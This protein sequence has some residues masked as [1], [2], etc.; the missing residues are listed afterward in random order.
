M[1]FVGID[2]E[3]ALISDERPFPALTCLTWYGPK[4]GEGL[5]LHADAPARALDIFQRAANGEFVVIAHN[6]AFDLAVLL[7]E[8]PQL[9]D[10][11]WRMLD[12]SAAQCTQLRESLS[13]LARGT[14]A[15]KMEGDAR[16]RWRT[17]PAT[18]QR[19]FFKLDL[20]SSL[21]LR[22]SIRIDK[23]KDTWRLRY[24]ALRDVPLD[25]WPPD[26]LTYAREDAQAH[27]LLARLQ[28][29]EATARPAL[30]GYNELADAPAQTRAAWALAL[31]RLAGIQTDPATT[32]AL[33]AS[34]AARAVAV[35]DDLIAVGL[36]R[37]AGFLVGKDGSLRP[38][39]S[40]TNAKDGRRTKEIQARVVAALGDATP[41][42]DKGSVSASEET[43]TLTGDPDLVK[44]ADFAHVQKL[45]SFAEGLDKGFAPRAIYCEWNTL[46]AN[47][48]TSSS[49]PNMQ[50][51]PREPGL[52]ECFV[53][54]PGYVLASVDYSALEL[55]TVAQVCV[56]IFGASVLADKINAGADLHCYLAA[57][58]EGLDVDT[59]VTSYKAG[60]PVAEERR[61]RAKPGNFGFWGGMGVERFRE[62]NWELG[63][64]AEAA[65]RLRN[66]WFEAYPE[67]RAYF[68][69]IGDLTR[70]GEAQ[71]VQYV[72]NRVRGGCGFTD[73][74]NTLFSGLAADGAK[75]ALY[76]IQ[77]ECFHV[78]SSP[79]Y[80]S[81]GVIFAHDEFILEVP[82]GSAHEAANRLAD[83]AR[84]TMQGYLPHVRVSTSKCLMRRWRKG[85]KE[86]YDATGARLIPYEDGPAFA[87]SLAQ[88]KVAV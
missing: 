65:E 85:A 40:E 55:C 54:R 75:R 81:W 84:E 37:P 33:R 74:C 78:P 32:V 12:A 83:L 69:Y 60:D 17:D 59:F 58:T 13:D 88:G 26:A 35:R 6:L 5:C 27:W 31:Q 47:G 24:G 53:P 67:A 9:N 77:R 56:W 2:T 4:Y 87:K 79:L 34:L 42:T 76:L 48:R 82:E 64:T 44:V 16:G 73:G 62:Q 43:L 70:T 68:K 57:V 15:Q 7:C 25:V 18:G 14:F 39:K 29:T 20:A 28:E 52:R 63:L 38:S 46:V 41:R 86:T 19:T 10:A 22:A 45:Q 1:E 61:Q 80:G 49:N 21:Y 36:L 72:S 51:L 50:Q 71:L 66:A 23:S 8:A 3:T 11:I 30:E